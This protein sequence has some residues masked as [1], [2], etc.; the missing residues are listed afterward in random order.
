M[1]LVLAISRCAAIPL[2]LLPVTKEKLSP[3]FPRQ[4][5]S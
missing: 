1:Q 4:I 3:M 5:L 2:A